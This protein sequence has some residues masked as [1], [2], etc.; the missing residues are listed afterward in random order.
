MITLQDCQQRDA[1]DPL[2]ALRDLFSIPAGV[3]YL[4]GNSLGVMPKAAAARA[5]EV[6]TQEWGTGLIRSTGRSS[7]SSCA[8]CCSVRS[9][10]AHGSWPP[11]PRSVPSA[12]PRP[13]SPSRRP[14]V[15]ARAAAQVWNP[16]TSEPTTSDQPSTIT[17]SSSLNGSEITTGGSTIMPIA[18]STDPTTRSSTRNGT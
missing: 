8:S 11:L 18:S 12:R 15:A 7:R 13:P 17:N 4:D 1:A 14:F 6:I 16:R 3:I 9:A 5:A 10:R 2:R